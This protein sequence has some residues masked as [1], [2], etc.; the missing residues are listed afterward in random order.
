MQS[1]QATQMQRAGV[2]AAAPAPARLL[3]LL[4][5]LSSSSHCS[6]RDTPHSLPARPQVQVASMGGMPR[7]MPRGVGIELDHSGGMGG[8]LGGGGLPLIGQEPTAQ[9]AVWDPGGTQRG[10]G[11]S[12]LGR[13][14]GVERSGFELGEH[15]SRDSILPATP[16][17]TLGHPLP[18][19]HT[20]PCPQRTSSRASR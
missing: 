11:C 18:T 12:V 15:E 19:A 9:D 13:A 20:A 17:H 7:G 10:L 1:L 6:S 2:L 4:P 3:P 5:P 16:R 8:G 14:W